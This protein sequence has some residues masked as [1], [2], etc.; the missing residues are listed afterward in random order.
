MLFFRVARYIN[1]LR[2]DE[3]SLIRDL[4]YR[5]VRDHQRHAVISPWSLMAAI[6]M[7]GR[8][9]LPIA[10]LV[11][12][13]DWIKRQAQNLGAYVDWPGEHGGGAEGGRGGINKRFLGGF[14]MAPLRKEMFLAKH[15]G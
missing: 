5:I 9:G 10:Q 12:D 15:L 4:A 6:L 11:R 13:T 2:R 14:L 8:D 1:S 3:T 7:Q